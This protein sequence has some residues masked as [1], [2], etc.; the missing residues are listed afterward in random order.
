MFVKAKTYSHRSARV[1]EVTS[2]LDSGAQSSF[3]STS[4][5]QRLSLNVQNP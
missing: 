1:E 4:S 2:L 5:V 3:I